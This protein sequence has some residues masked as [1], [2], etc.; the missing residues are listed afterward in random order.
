MIWILLSLLYVPNP[1]VVQVLYAEVDVVYLHYFPDNVD[2]EPQL[3][4]VIKGRCLF[5][6]VN[7]DHGTDGKPFVD[8]Q[9]KRIR[10]EFLTIIPSSG[11]SEEYHFKP[12]PISLIDP[13]LANLNQWS[14]AHATKCT[15]NWD[16]IQSLDRWRWI[17]LDK[18]IVE[19]FKDVVLTHGTKLPPERKGVWVK[20]KGEK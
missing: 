16:A 18:E 20:V 12:K 9:G 13:K 1:P 14:H 6:Y 11:Y 10:R 19:I 17:C 15:S 4:E 2:V 5:L 3:L 8:E 7:S